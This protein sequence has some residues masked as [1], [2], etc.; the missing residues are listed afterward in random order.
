MR[1]SIKIMCIY[2]MRKKIARAFLFIYFRRKIDL[3][4]RVR[5]REIAA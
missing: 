2:L 3:N 4:Q 1:C 5:E